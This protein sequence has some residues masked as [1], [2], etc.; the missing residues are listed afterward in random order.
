MRPA[1]ASGVPLAGRRTMT[2]PP[3]PSRY[4]PSPE[5]ARDPQDRPPMEDPRPKRPPVGDPPPEEP[6]RR[7]PPPPS[8][9]P[10]EPPRVIEDP[11]APG[12][13]PKDP[14]VIARGAIPT[15]PIPFP[16]PTPGPGPDPMPRPN[17][18]PGPIPRQGSA[19]KRCSTPSRYA[20]VV[21]QREKLLQ[22]RVLVEGPVARER[23]TRRAHCEAQPSSLINT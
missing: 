12:S 5:P 1:G 20:S 23:K 22:Q 19:I 11:P 3:P 18:F 13:P 10:G 21:G 6:I 7:D 14:G 4:T 15:P 2:Q 17:P 16:V 8:P 9:E